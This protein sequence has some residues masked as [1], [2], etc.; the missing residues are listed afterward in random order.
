MHTGL[1]DQIWLSVLSLCALAVC[2][3]L[4]AQ[5]LA[6]WWWNAAVKLQWGKV[7][8]CYWCRREIKEDSEANLSIFLGMGKSQSFSIASSTSSQYNFLCQ[9][10]LPLLYFYLF[11]SCLFWGRFVSAMCIAFL[12]HWIRSQATSSG[13]LATAFLGLPLGL[14]NLWQ[15]KLNATVLWI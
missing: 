5:T 4:G 14:W 1:G 11:Q 9:S 12:S 7:R 3:D 10:E 13:V 2:E 8:R 6:F 15:V